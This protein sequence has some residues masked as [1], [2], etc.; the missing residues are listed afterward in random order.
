LI[1]LYLVTLRLICLVFLIV[2]SLVDIMSWSIVY[3]SVTVFTSFIA[4]IY[5]KQELKCLRLD[6]LLL[7][8][9]VSRGI[10][11][12]LSAMAQGQYA[13]LD[14]ILIERLLGFSAVGIY[15]AAQRIIV[16]GYMPI[17]AIMTSSYAGFFRYGKNG[18][19]DALLYARK[20]SKISVTIGIL[21]SIGLF[22]CADLFMWILGNT[23]HEIALL[24]RILACIPLLQSIYSLFSNALAGSGFVKYRT[25]AYLMN[26]GLLCALMFFFT[27]QLNVR[28]AALSLLLCEASLIIIFYLC[29]SFIQRMQ[30]QSSSSI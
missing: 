12:S 3:A 11:F 28:G 24:I 19:K 2:F 13:N 18:L 26:I 8:K 9:D 1:Q 10:H 4:L 16:L 15:S 17:N 7:K 30:S 21:S 27:R 25:I 23:Y 20:I 5:V 22:L 29:C 6:L 14:K